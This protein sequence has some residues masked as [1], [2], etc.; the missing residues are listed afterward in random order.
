M[1]KLYLRLSAPI[2]VKMQDENLIAVPIKVVKRDLYPVYC[3]LCI[4]P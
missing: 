4:L 1:T 3:F 2:F